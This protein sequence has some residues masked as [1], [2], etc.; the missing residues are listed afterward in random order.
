MRVA[1]LPRAVAS[2]V[3][4]IAIS[5]AV[6]GVALTVLFLSV[7]VLVDVLVDRGLER[8]LPL[9]L[10][11]LAVMVAL[12]VVSGWRPSKWT[13]AL[14]L[15]GGAASALV[16]AVALLS[17]DPT[18]DDEAGFLLNRPALV[19]VLGGVAV[20]RPA[21]GLAWGLVGYVLATAV[22]MA[23]SLI[24]GVP[25]APGWGPT[26][27]VA[28]Y[29][30]G[31]AALAVVSAAQDKRVPDLARLEED[32]RRLSIENQ[33]EQRAAALVHDTVLSDL[34][35]VMNAAGPLDDRA[36]ARFRA[37]VATLSNSA[38]LRESADPTLD[39]PADAVL[40]N[41]L[42]ALV[43]DFQWRGLRVDVTGDSATIIR[44]S[45]EATSSLVA[46]V[47]A[48]LDNVLLHAGTGSAELVISTTEH[49]ATV[50]VIDHGRGFDPNGV[51]DDRLG[52]RSA[53]VNRISAHGGSVRVWSTPGDGTS[54]LISVPGVDLEKPQGAGD[55]A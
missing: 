4:A 14:F 42:E 40:R 36:R 2:R 37:D 22:S 32:T 31:C 41:S 24:V 47:R 16:Y 1:I 52:L 46:A 8:H 43:S 10:A 26:I 39:A 28:V 55:D 11:C 23:S 20:A 15:V 38:W 9:P 53:V 12:L 7:P 19:L 54:V 50:M 35:A 45:A 51:A 27:A 44:I 21:I 6:W 34:T 49:A 3:I 18:L 5:R 25:I 48:C 29:A 33:F 17:A 13:R 30:G